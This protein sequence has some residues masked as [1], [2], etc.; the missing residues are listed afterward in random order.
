MGDGSKQ[1]GAEGLHLSVYAFFTSDV[2]LFIDALSSNFNLKCT[3]HNTDRGP[4]I[5]INKNY[6]NILRPIVSPYI[7][8]SMN[9]KIGL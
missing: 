2:N 6:M 8:A 5:Y 9:Y 4:R 1:A 7:V 3:I